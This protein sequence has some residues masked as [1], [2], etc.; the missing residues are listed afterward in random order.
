MKIKAHR[1]ANS[2]H[3]LQTLPLVNKQNVTV[4]GPFLC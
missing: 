1:S 3:E 4:S 2:A